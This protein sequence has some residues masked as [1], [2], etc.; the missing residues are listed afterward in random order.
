MSPLQRPLSAGV[1]WLTGP[2]REFQLTSSQLSGCSVLPEAS[3]RRMFRPSCH[4]AFRQHE[5]GPFNPL[6]GARASPREG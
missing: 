6:R 3:P 2:T 4:F 5:L 1:A